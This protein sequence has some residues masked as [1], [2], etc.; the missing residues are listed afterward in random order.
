MLGSRGFTVCQSSGQVPPEEVEYLRERFC[1]EEE[2]P[3]ADIIAIPVDVPW[4]RR[5]PTGKQV[6]SYGNA[7]PFST[8]SVSIETDWKDGHDYYIVIG[9][10]EVL[11]PIFMLNIKQRLLFR[12]AI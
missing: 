6:E 9:R 2:L 10:K 8:H 3:L 11:T 12:G 4:T 5:K 1:R 7:G